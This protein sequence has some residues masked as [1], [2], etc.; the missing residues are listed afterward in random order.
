MKDFRHSASVKPL[1][2]TTNWYLCKLRKI[3]WE[4]GMD[5][6]NRSEVVMI[7]KRKERKKK[8][9]SVT[10]TRTHVWTRNRHLSVSFYTLNYFPS[11]QTITILPKMLKKKKEKKRKEKRNQHKPRRHPRCRHW[12]VSSRARRPPV[13][14]SVTVLCLS[15]SLQGQLANDDSND[16]E[17]H[18]ERQDAGA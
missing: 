6:K 9:K 12:H 15:V 2:H 18:T 11:E 8:A 7:Y 4:G 3:I 13:R 1:P 5:G 17:E 14:P 10:K 16:K